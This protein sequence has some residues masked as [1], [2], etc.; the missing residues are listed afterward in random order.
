MFSNL[1]NVLLTLRTFLT[2][3]FDETFPVKMNKV[4][5]NSLLMNHSFVCPALLE[6]KTCKAS[7][8]VCTQ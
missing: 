1:E 7:T 3:V 6:T 8:G 2:S 4:A 5:P